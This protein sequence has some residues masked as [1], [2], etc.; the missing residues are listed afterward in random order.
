LTAIDRVTSAWT[1]GYKFSKQFR[2]HVWDGKTRLYWPKR[3]M[4]PSGLLEL[5]LEALRQAGCSFRSVKINFETT[6][7]TP[8][9]GPLADG[10]V[11][12]D[13]QREAVEAFIFKGRG[14]LQVA[15]AGGKTA[16]TAAIIRSFN[17]PTLMIIYGRT[18]LAETRTKLE[19][20]LGEKVGLVAGKDFSLGKRVTLVSVNTAFAHLTSGNPVMTELLLHAPLLICDE[21]HRSTA[22]T[23]TKLLQSASAHHRL[24]LSGTPLKRKELADLQLV[25]WTG[26]VIYEASAH[27][28]QEAGFLS[29]ATLSIVEV[30][31]PKLTIQC[32]V[33][34]GRTKS[35]ERCK[36]WP[37]VMQKLVIG[38]TKRTQRLVELV[39]NRAKAGHKVFVLAG[40]TLALTH[41]L[42]KG[43]EERLQGRYGVEC[44]TGKSG[45]WNNQEALKRF[46]AGVSSVL[47]A[48]VVMDEGIDAPEADVVVLANAGRSYVKVMQRIG[49]GL[50]LKAGGGGLEVIDV[51]DHTHRML[52]T[53][54]L[55][56]I[57]YYESERLFSS[58]TIIQ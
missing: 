51:M 4:F 17:C 58:V 31:E 56:R 16:I 52:R 35:R 46:R 28:L 10:T 23:W 15:T 54:A 41:E 24:G 22:M 2:A 6:P 30:T 29:Q 7:A 53:H 32:R 25:A 44:L 27:N 39:V 11:L 12:R 43:I 14:V 1:P 33:C 26:P 3:Q 34:A 37:D 13:Y 42:Y 48:S 50:R 36:C 20:Y 45:A 5:V 8:E 19:E 18:L 55:D 40:N 47:V 38:N 49:R 9:F 21:V 57:S